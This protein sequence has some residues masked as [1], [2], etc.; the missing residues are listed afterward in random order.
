MLSGG[1]EETRKSKKRKGCVE[2]YSKGEVI[3]LLLC[4]WVGCLCYFI[5]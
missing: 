5:V 4:H 3:D 2:N 1:V